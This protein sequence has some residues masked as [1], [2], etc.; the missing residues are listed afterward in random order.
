MRND[1]GVCVTHEIVGVTAKEEEKENR[2]FCKGVFYAV[3]PKM[4]GQAQ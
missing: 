1:I 2:R 3:Y 4:H